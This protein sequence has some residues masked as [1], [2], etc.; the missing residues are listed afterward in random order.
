MIYSLNKRKNIIEWAKDLQLNGFSKPGKPGVICVEG[1][2]LNV[3]E[4]LTRLKSMNWQR[5]TVINSNISIFE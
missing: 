3:L 5:L 1:N 4:Y 2:H